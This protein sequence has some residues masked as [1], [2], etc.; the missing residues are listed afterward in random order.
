MARGVKKR[1]GPARALRDP[2]Y[3]K[4]VTRDRTKYSR[5]GKQRWSPGKPGDHALLILTGTEEES[6]TL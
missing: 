6:W 4:R 5:K 1:N 2:R 3:R